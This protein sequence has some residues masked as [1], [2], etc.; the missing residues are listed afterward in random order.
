MRLID[1]L[2][3]GLAV[4]GVLYAA[5]MLIA[6]VIVMPWLLTCREEWPLCPRY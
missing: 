4:V 3:T 2:L 1:W 6:V 5:G